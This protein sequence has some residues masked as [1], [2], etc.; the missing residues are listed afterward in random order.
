MPRYIHTYIHATY[1]STWFSKDR[2]TGYGEA[3][4]A[5]S[6]IASSTSCR[7]RVTRLKSG[8]VKHN[9]SKM[10]RDLNELQSDTSD[11]ANVATPTLKGIS[12]V[13]VKPWVM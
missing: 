8:V 9:L 5:L 6:A 12:V 1:E 3:L 13:M 2:M 11:R 4:K 7:E 10:K